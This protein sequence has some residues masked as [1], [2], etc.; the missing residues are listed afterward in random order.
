[1]GNPPTPPK[2]GACNVCPP[3]HLL[4]AIYISKLLITSFI[5]PICPSNIRRLMLRNYLYNIKMEE[6]ANME[7]VL[8]K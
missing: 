3:S 2:L 7:E 1:M 4:H 5:H 6:G 8:L